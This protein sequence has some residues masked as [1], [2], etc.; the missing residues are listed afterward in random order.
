MYYY[1]IRVH[2]SSALSAVDACECGRFLI[3]R[4]CKSGAEA[5]CDALQKLVK[6]I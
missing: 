3:P 1:G 5:A 6:E 2:E 4:F